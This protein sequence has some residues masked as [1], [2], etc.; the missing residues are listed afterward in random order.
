MAAGGIKEPDSLRKPQE[1]LIP[2]GCDWL[3]AKAQ[4]FEPES[5]TIVL[6]NGQKVKYD[7]LVMAAGI[8]INF[9]GVNRFLN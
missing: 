9:D 8:Q 1:K 6:D 3:K 2:K 7:Y 5:N 4:T